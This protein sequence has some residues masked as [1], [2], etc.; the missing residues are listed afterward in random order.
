MTTSTQGAPTAAYLFRKQR[1]LPGLLH[2]PRWAAQM[3]KKKREMSQ[4]QPTYNELAAS[5]PSVMS[6]QAFQAYIHALIRVRT[7]L[8]DFNAHYNYCELRAV[9]KRARK[10]KMDV[11][12]ERLTRNF[13]T[14]DMPM[15]WSI[16]PTGQNENESGGQSGG[17]R[18]WKLTT[19]LSSLPLVTLI[20]SLR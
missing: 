11:I 15:Q 6:V 1:I 16:N 5:P 4:I 20:S 18:D 19:A 14:L 12:T 8:F 2:V 3:E 17:N 10:R 7:R 9:L 13:P